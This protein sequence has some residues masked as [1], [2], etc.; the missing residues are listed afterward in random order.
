MADVQQFW[1]L[2]PWDKSFAEYIF[3][4]TFYNIKENKMLP[5]KLW[6]Y[7]ILVILEFISIVTKMVLMHDIFEDF[8]QIIPKWPFLA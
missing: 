6:L 4:T 8:A 7:R 2:S 1:N 3:L 5:I